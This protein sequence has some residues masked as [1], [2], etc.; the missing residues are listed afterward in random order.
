MKNKYFVI[1]G[2]LILSLVFCFFACSSNKRS[3]QFQIVFTASQM[4]DNAIS[5]YGNF[6][7]EQIPELEINGSAPL[8]T[9]IAMGEAMQNIDP[10]M[11]MGSTMRLSALMAAGELDMVIGTLEN[12]SA[13]A[14]GGS[15]LPLTD[16]FSDAELQALGD[17]L[18]SF[19]VVNVNENNVRVPTGER[20]PALGFSITGND[21]IRAIFGNQE[22]GVYIIANTKN[23]E[24]AKTVMRTFI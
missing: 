19:D 14:Q 10:M 21:Q 20:T 1:K 9:P 4:S 11:A 24:L 15:F 7:L 16:I 13:M 17:R 23:P 5:A 22:I 18:I 2:I 12:V 3:N 6:L 8:F